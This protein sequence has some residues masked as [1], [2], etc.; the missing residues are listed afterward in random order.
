M[1]KHIDLT[2]NIINEIRGL[3]ARKKKTANEFVV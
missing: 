1:P 3:R 2:T